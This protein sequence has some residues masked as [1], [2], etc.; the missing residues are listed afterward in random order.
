VRNVPP[1]IRALR[2]RR[3]A[4]VAASQCGVVSVRQLRTCG[5]SESTID[6][7]RE[8]GILHRRLR[9]ELDFDQ[10]H[11]TAHAAQTDAR[12]DADR[13]GAGQRVLPLRR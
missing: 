4:E 2:Y 5:L 6:R 1:A 9:L 11:G 10:T 3:V 13:R 7:W 12:R 8:K